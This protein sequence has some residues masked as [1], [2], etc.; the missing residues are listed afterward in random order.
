MGPDSAGDTSI[1]VLYVDDDPTVAEMVGEYLLREDADIVVRTATS[2]EEGLATAA[3]WDVDCIVSDYDM[4]GQDG[5]EF[6]AAV[7]EEYEAL[8]FILHTGEGSESVAAEAISR[9][10]TDYLRKETGTDQY[11]ILANRIANAVEQRRERTVRR[12]VERRFAELAGQS[13]DVLWMFTPGW[14]ELLFVNEAYEEVY[15]ASRESL[16]VEPRSFLDAIHP[17]DRP[18]VREGMRRLSA[19]EDVDIEYR[20]NEADDYGR[21]VW[22]QGTAVTNDEGTVTAVTGFS[23]EVTDRKER[24]RELERVRN[25]MEF[26]L[27]STDA[28]VWDWNVDEDHVT[29]YPS[30]EE[31][32]GTTVDTWE[33]FRN[34]V[35]PDDR[36]AVRESI[37]RAL[38][39]GEPKYEEVR[40]VRDGEVQWVNAPG[41]PVRDEDGT[42][43]MI[44]VVR[45][46]TD[47]KRKERELREKN[48]RLEEFAEIVSHDL[49][50][51]LSVA[52]GRLEMARAERDGEHLQEID[53]AL[54]RM[55]LLID[56]L[57]ALARSEEVASDVTTVDLR[58]VVEDCWRSVDT[59]DATL[60]VDCDERVRADETLF[61]QLLENLIRNAVEHGGRDVTV[62]VGAT[63]GGIY[64][65][66]DG[67]GLPADD[68]ESVFEAGY[69]TSSDG[70]GLG[71]TIVERVVEAHDW[72]ID[73]T[74]SEGDGTRF[75][76]AGVDAVD[77]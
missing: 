14:D 6:L 54:D 20:V 63:D 41:Y 10:A 27:E 56:D 71:L 13:P 38:E 44:G 57:L 26:A 55:S 61:H 72:T 59:A 66:D 2:A 25:R 48:E 65:A 8:P 40:I 22:V 29:F 9:G 12:T 68:P 3:E 77:E 53:Y 1:R 15:G 45:D 47:R 4:S 52:E 39:T 73:I 69:T 64:V 24:E 21:W 5:L 51:P 70:T 67:K 17:E 7:R 35:H 23:R 43:R 49:R 50:N 75:E 74:S 32:Y 19:G 58:A 46:V 28:F 11:A 16:S 60:S 30:E 36:A 33:D 42:Q 37:D 34:L 31:L 76:I 18:R 62:T